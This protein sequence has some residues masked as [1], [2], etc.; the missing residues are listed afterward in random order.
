MKLSCCSSTSDNV[1]R[2]EVR[3]H[4]LEIEDSKSFSDCCFATSASC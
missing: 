1:V 2:V 4:V 3:D